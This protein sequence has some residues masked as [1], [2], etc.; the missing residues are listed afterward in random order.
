VGSRTRLSARADLWSDDDED[1]LG[2]ELRWALRDA[3]QDGG[4]L[5]LALFT[6]DARFSS[7]SGLRASLRGT[8]GKG[9]WNVGLESALFDQ[10]NFFGEQGELWQHLLRGGYDLG[11]G[12]RWDLSLWGDQRLGD[13]QEATTLGLSL[14]RRF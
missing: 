7:V 5:A 4:E 3:F 6:N 8:A 13:E 1:G 14:R 11:L 2:G 12:A 10:D 9:Y